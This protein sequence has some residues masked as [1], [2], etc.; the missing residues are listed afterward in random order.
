MS[1]GL[2]PALLF[3]ELDGRHPERFDASRC[4]PSMR[5]RDC[6][7]AMNLAVHDVDL[8]LHLLRAPLTVEPRATFCDAKSFRARLVGP[9]GELVTVAV[10]ESDSGV[11]SVVQCHLTEVGERFLA[12]DPVGVPVIC[13][14]A[15]EF[16]PA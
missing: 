6:S 9:Q 7:V 3:V 11:R 10:V 4:L 13:G 12:T 2:G 16:L 15:G 1:K 5:A 14:P 8:A